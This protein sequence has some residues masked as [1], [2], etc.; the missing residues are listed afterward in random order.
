M[1]DQMEPI[2]APVILSD[3]QKLFFE[4]EFLG[5]NFSWF[6]MPTETIGPKIETPCPTNWTRAPVFNRTIVNRTNPS[7]KRGYVMSQ[8]HWSILYPIFNA[9]IDE[10]GLSAPYI[11]RCGIN[12]SLH[13]P[14]DH[15]EPHMDHPYPHKNWIWYLD[16]VDA[17]TVLFDADLN[18]TH[19]IPCVKD[20]AAVFDGQ[21]HAQSYPPPCTVRRVVV[22]TFGDDPG[23]IFNASTSTPGP[24]LPPKPE[25]GLLSKPGPVLPEDG[26]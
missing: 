13:Q 8:H 2:I 10:Q 22:I 23:R 11:Y 3:E 6:Y 9:W 24:V 16:T 26:R 18:I 1:D 21:M 4:K 20:T 19:R 25:S 14:F 12:C 15:S 7:V 17:P 5:N